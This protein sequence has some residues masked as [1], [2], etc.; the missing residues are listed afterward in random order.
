MKLAGFHDQAM[1]SN[2]ISLI[3]MHIPA[4][5]AINATAMMKRGERRKGSCS[6]HA[7]SS[8]FRYFIDRR[9]DKE[10]YFDIE[11]IS[12]V[13]RT[14]Q[15]LDREDTPWHN[16]TV[17]ATEEGGYYQ[18]PCWCNFVTLITCKLVFQDKSLQ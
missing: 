17:M 6:I 1:Y 18:K 5:F 16:I 12:G 2:T 9:E 13:I 4:V 14:T 10:V 15:L 11:S 7:L 8:I 3:I